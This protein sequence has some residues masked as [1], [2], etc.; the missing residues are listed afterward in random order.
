MERAHRRR[1]M[2]SD[3][4]LALI[5]ERLDAL[6]NLT[7]HVWTDPKQR[8]SRM[9]KPFRYRRPVAPPRPKPS[10]LDEMKRFFGRR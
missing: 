8:P 1:W 7:A 2:H 6:H 4:I 5:L 9:P 10:T 3:E